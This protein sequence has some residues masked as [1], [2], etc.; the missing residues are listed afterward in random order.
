MNI[1]F[2]ARHTDITPDIKKYCERR[3]R[4]L[5]KVL[6]QK[7]SADNVLSVEKNRHKV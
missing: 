6:G 5:E 7:L 3:L 1:N 4:S 2:T